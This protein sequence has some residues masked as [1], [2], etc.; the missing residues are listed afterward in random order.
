MPQVGRW[1]QPTTNRWPRPVSCMRLLDGT[2]SRARL[3][4]C[5]R[6]PGYRCP[7]GRPRPD[8]LLAGSSDRLRTRRSVRTPSE[9]T[10]IRRALLVLPARHP[11]RSGPPR[12]PAPISPRP[13]MATERFASMRGLS[14]RSLPTLGLADGH[15]DTVSAL[16][17]HTDGRPEGGR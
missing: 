1:C 16:D 2:L 11:T 14:D 7:G 12:A 17:P 4:G 6:D 13:A 9:S 15:A 8:R 3:A 10:A 5:A